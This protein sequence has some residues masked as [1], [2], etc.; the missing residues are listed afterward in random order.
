ML[1]HVEDCHDDVERV[2]DQ[3]D[4]HK[5]LEDPFEEYK[6]FKVCQVVV[7]DDQ[8]DQLITGDERQKHARYGNDD[9]FGDAAHKGE[10]TPARSSPGCS[11]PVSQRQPPAG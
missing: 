8:L 5:S 4:S 10:N 9:R 3:H 7:F 1:R 2:G 11:L 6:C